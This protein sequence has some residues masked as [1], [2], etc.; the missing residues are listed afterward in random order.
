MQLRRISIILFTVYIF[1]AANVCA[2]WICA[3]YDTS[4]L[5]NI[6]K[7]YNEFSDGSYTGGTKSI[8]LCPADIEWRQEYELAYPHSG[9]DSLYLEGNPQNITRY[10]NLLPQWETRFSDYFWELSGNH[11]IYQRRQTNIPGLGWRWDFCDYKLTDDALCVSTNRYADV[12]T[13]YRVYGAGPFNLQGYILSPEEKAMYRKFGV[14]DALNV[15]D[16]IPGT[17]DMAVTSYFHSSNLSKRDAYGHYIHSDAEIADMAGSVVSKYLTGPSLRG[18]DP[19]KD[20]AT[21]YL[22][23]GDIWKWDGDIIKYGGGKVGW[24]SVMY[25]SAPPY[26]QYQYLIVNG[27]V[28]DG[29]NDLPRIF[30]YTGGKA[31]PEIVWKSVFYKNDADRKN[32]D[33]I[34]EE[35]HLDPNGLTAHLYPH[36]WHNHS[37]VEFK[38]LDGRLSLDQSG[39]PVFRPSGSYEN[40]YITANASHIFVWLPNLDTPVQ[41]IRRTEYNDDCS[42][43]AK[44]FAVVYHR[45]SDYYTKDA[46]TIGK[47]DFESDVKYLWELGYTFCTADEFNSKIMNGETGKYVAITFDDGYSSE[48]ESILAILEKYRAKAT[49]FIVGELV[50]TDGYMSAEQIRQLSR[51]ELVQI[52]NHSY[53]LHNIGYSNIRDF[54]FGSGCRAAL[55]DYNMNK[56]MLEEVTGKRV[57]AI[58]YPYG[59]YGRYFDHVQKENGVTT[60]CSKEEPAKNTR[61]YGRY[62]RSYDI[63]IRDIIEKTKL[64]PH[65][66]Q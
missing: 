20:I 50:G 16:I 51:S 14:A 3:G 45:I 57:D 43:N 5:N 65:A 61:P 29:H 63:T 44:P 41:V 46:Y 23:H 10:N 25:E 36:E 24:T 13:D 31:S 1:S 27:I 2:E 9:Y 56:T 55:E 52:G 22:K 7:I 59:I 6:C 30:R 11:L 18:D 28:F 54:Y 39:L 58:S 26:L 37:I 4:D 32:G 53:F 40:C 35:N 47:D 49:F 19:T 21:E 17:K 8:P 42:C 15:F 34:L 38:Y 64:P 60:F 12:Q 62:N 66:A 33:M 48:I